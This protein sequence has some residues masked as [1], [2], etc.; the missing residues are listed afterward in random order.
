MSQQY[1]DCYESSLKNAEELQGMKDAVEQ[2]LPTA[3]IFKKLYN[4]LKLNREIYVV[5]GS[6]I[7][8][9][10]PHKGRHIIHAWIEI[11][12]T[13]IETS[14]NQLDSYPKEEYY[15]THSI[16]PII[17][18]SVIE[19]LQKVEKYKIFGPWHTMRPK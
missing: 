10:G 6:A 2:S 13:V 12:D 18:Y 17:R 4:D 16:N 15:K 7:P 14:N 1:G 19:A 11:G 8:P 5:H 9:I 3:Y